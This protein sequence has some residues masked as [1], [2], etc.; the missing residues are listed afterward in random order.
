MTL[1]LLIGLAAA[2]DLS[3]GNR[4]TP[5]VIQ[6][7]APLGIAQGTTAELNIEGLNLARAS[8]IYFSQPSLKGRVVRVKELPDAPEKKRLGSGGLP[9]TVD[10]GPLPP[11]NLVTVEVTASA[12]ADV[13]PVRFRLLTPLGTTPEGRILIEPKFTE[14]VDKEPND[15]PDAAVEAKLPAVL[16]GTISRPGDVDYYKIDVHAG[17]EIVFQDGAAKLGSELRPLI[18]IIAPDRSVAAAS[19]PGAPYFAHRFDKDGIY[20]VRVGDALE[21]GSNNHFYRILAGHLPLAHSAFPLGLQRGKTADVAFKG[22]FLGSGTFP[23][24]G[25]PSPDNDDAVTFR[26]QTPQGKTLNS[27]ELAIGDEPEIQ[28][29]GTNLSAAA[30][31]RVEAPVTINGI[32]DKPVEN[33]FRFAAHKGERFIID[34]AAA[35]LGSK[36]DSLIE[37]LDNRGNPVERATVR[38]TWQTTITLAEASSSSRGIRLTSWND[39]AVGDYMMVGRELIRV[40]RLPRNP[41]EDVFFESFD[42]QRLAWFDTSSEAHATDTPVYKVQIYPPG[43]R[44]PSNGLPLVHLDYRNDDGGPGYGRDSRL[45]FTAPA[46]GDYIVRIRDVSGLGGDNYAYR[47]SIRHPRPDFSLTMEPR[48]PNVPAGGRVPVT[49][50]AMRRDDFDGPIEVAVQ[51]L[52]A[53]LHATTG[54]IGAGQVSTV[55][56][57]SADENATL[58]NAAPLQV[59]GTAH[60]GERVATHYANP[61]DH[62]K[63]VALMPKADVLMTADSR[64]VEIEPGG[65][66]DVTVHITRQ[67]QF[68]GRVPVEVS[69][70]PPG[71]FLPTIGL[72]GILINETEE[73]RTFQIEALP[74]AQPI[75]QT[76]YVAGRVETR[77]PLE[78]SYAAEPITPTRKIARAN[79][80]AVTGGN[81]WRTILQE[82]SFCSVLELLHPSSWAPGT[83]PERNARWSATESTPTR[84]I[85]TGASCLP[86]SVTATPT[87]WWRIRKAASTYTTPF[88]LPAKTPIPW[89]YSMG[90]AGSSSPGA[91][92]SRAVRTGCISARKAAPSSFTS[93][94]P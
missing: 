90:R 70:L 69:N 61:D 58:T 10:L 32:I 51:D 41:D 73:R 47:L 91:S 6:S 84:S 38:C 53:G 43:Q 8:A 4:T 75:E 39:V 17:E 29:G 74:M 76:I 1:L 28:S 83:R 93:A 86:A 35:R 81:E 20:Y 64:V 77:S 26:P 40:E 46:D 24:S 36:L 34:V 52:P 27:V 88:T 37:V 31:Q 23:V 94:T 25:R 16:G 15:T 18:S 2:A 92:S 3:T 89:W 72:N 59:A 50:T 85:T 62:L 30:A 13:G 45:H 65:R 49:L 67:N 9:D 14:A 82:D 5:P 71:V 80:N 57:L 44:F 33:D 87:A 22:S 63:M 66:A 12:D 79:R 56:L 54:T 60:F 48:N 7:V 68:G 42:D 11:R 78:S 21:A 55:L 19:A